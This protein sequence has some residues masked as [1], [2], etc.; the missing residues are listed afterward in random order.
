MTSPPV[1]PSGRTFRVN[2]SPSAERGKKNE[3]GVCTPLRRP[4]SLLK[5]PLIPL[6]ERGTNNRLPLIKGDK[7]GI[8]LEK[9]DRRE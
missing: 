8:L 6:Y 7:R 1:S 2:P 5:T 3:R 9:I 4:G